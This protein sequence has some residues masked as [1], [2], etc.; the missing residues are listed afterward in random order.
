MPLAV[1]VS[2]KPAGRIYTFDPGGLDLQTG[3]KVVTETARGEEIGS[4]KHA[5][6]ELRDDQVVLPLK[7]ILRLANDEDRARARAN[8][9]KAEQALAIS[10]ERVVARNLPMKLVRAEYAFDRTQVTIYF[11]QKGAWTSGSW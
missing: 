8:E 3:S 6:R 2:F 10:R 11:R 5:A 1:G 7:R 9:E 4:V